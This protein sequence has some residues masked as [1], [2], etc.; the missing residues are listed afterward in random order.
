MNFYNLYIK[1]YNKH[2]KQSEKSILHEIEE[3]RFANYA[4]AKNLDTY[5]DLFNKTNKLLQENNIYNFFNKYDDIL[6]LNISLTEEKAFYETFRQL[7]I[8]LNKLNVSL[9]AEFKAYHDICDWLTKL[10]FDATSISKDNNEETKKYWIGAESTEFVQL[11][12]ALIEAGRLQKKDKTKMIENTA[13]F[14]GLELSKEWASN[15]SKSV[16]SRNNDYEPPI[17]NDLKNGW[18]RYTSKK[19]T[20]S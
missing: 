8:N 12:Y 2:Y 14:L 9:I 4:I 11:M 6:G 20:K 16:H 15:L 18:D 3:A 1:S 10:S 17:F 13:T 5:R 19:T 7:E